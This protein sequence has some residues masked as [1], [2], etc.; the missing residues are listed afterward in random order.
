[1]TIIGANGSPVLC[2]EPRQTHLAAEP[3]AQELALALQFARA[4]KSDARRL[5]RPIARGQWWA[6]APD[7]L[8]GLRDRALLLMGFAAALPRSELVGLDVADLKQSKVGMRLRIRTSKTDQDRQSVSVAI[9]P[10]S[11]TCPIASLNK[12]LATAGIDDGP[13][14]RPVFKG[15][16]VANARLSDRAVAEIVKSYATRIGLDPTSYSGYSLRAGFLTSAA[17]RGASIFKMT[18]VSRHRSLDTL[19]G[20]VRD[21][22][23]FHN[24]AGAGLL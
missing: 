4:E 16:R 13:V 19:S 3:P 24:H 11:S 5:S 15:G 1:M 14:F 2:V 9:A 7:N 6:A 17:Q 8:I 23:F 10:G 20:F 18:D 21:S 22:E 12:W